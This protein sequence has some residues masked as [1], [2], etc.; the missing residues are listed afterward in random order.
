MNDVDEAIEN[1]DKQ[2]QAQVGV[3]NTGRGIIPNAA[4]LNALIEAKTHLLAMQGTSKKGPAVAV[5]GLTCE[6]CGTTGLN[7]AMYGRW[8]GD[9][10]KSKK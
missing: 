2:I 9:K 10:C 4:G 6:H 3:L 7:K 1:I 5:E 8:H